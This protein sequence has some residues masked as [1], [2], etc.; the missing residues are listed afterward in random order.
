MIR[1]LE[2][3][4]EPDGTRQLAPP[5]ATIGEPLGLVSE[6]H[7]DYHSDSTGNLGFSGTIQVAGELLECWE[8]SPYLSPCLHRREDLEHERRVLSS[9]A[10]IDRIGEITAAG[11][12]EMANMRF[13]TE[14]VVRRFSSD[15][16]APDMETR[17]PM[18]TQTV[19]VTRIAMITDEITPL[20]IKGNLSVQEERLFSRKHNIVSVSYATNELSSFMVSPMATALFEAQLTA[21]RSGR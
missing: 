1:C 2:L 5:W 13:P 17:R 6:I 3:F 14:L 15:S 12:K 20:P 21:K 16:Q 8:D 18:G 19:S 7:Y 11:F 4:P 9:A 10:L